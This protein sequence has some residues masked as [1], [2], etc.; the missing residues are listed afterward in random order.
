[1]YIVTFY[2]FKGGVGRSMS[3]V[4]VGVQLA[5]A[6][7]KVLL[8]DFDLE[9][10][11]LPTFNLAKP[12]GDAPGLVEYI[13]HYTGTG[14][15]PDVTNHIYKS[16][17]FQSGG[18]WVMPAGAQDQT[19]SQRLN[20]IDWRKLYEE[21]SG[22]LFFEDLKSQWKEALSPDYV[23]IDSRTG[24]SDVEGICTRQLPDAVSLLF[25]PNEQN[26]QGLKR[27]VANI[28]SDNAGKR[29]KPI[30]LHFVVSNVPDLD[31]EDHI[32][33]KTMLRFR[34]ELAYRD[35]SSEIHHYNSLSLLN[36][37]IFSLNRPNSRLT[38]EY[39]KLTAAI[40]SRNFEDRDAVLVF[41]KDTHGNIS[42]VME[43]VGPRILTNRLD[44]IRENFEHDGEVCFYLAKLQEQIGS[45]DDALALLSS[46]AVRVGFATG[47]MFAARASLNRRIGNRDEAVRDLYS[48]L[49]SQSIDL[50]S[51]LEA[52]PVLDRLAPQ[53]YDS[54]PT[55]KAFLSLSK[56]DQVFFV[57]QSEGK[58]NQL[59]A[60]AEILKR[61][62]ANPEFEVDS[63]HSPEDFL[64]HELVL[65]SIGTGDF[66]TA[67][68]LLCPDNRP[69]DDSSIADAF[70]LAMAVWGRDRRPNRDLF[71][72]VANKDRKD[73]K[74]TRLGA[75]YLQC[76]AITYSVIGDVEKA[77]QFL[78][79]SRKAITTR[80]QREFSAWSYSKVAPSEFLKHLDQISAMASGDAGS[81]E[82]LMQ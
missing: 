47:A 22:Y 30:S 36:Q 56:K 66:E 31:D 81:P 9:A 64:V 49:D 43:S 12:D 65:A 46:E 17:Q 41:L 35:L 37:E 18:L 59:K 57:L 53:L 21:Q 32:L 76:M 40:R 51:F 69:L 62:R 79:T 1:M 42:E 10:P 24:H 74:D 38:K 61:L 54:L 75:N 25:F 19:Y 11:G 23:L 82:F 72:S 4:N 48:M 63:G 80:P 6:G 68:Q 58:K 27:I 3:L 26:L 7:R 50:E 70:N 52:M 44:T 29:E 2:S 33:R 67:I 73:P 13:S 60:N 45:I 28:R 5:Q 20:S 16:E 34:D 77:K 55:S 71:E 8:V 78:S 39:A 15:A 14:E